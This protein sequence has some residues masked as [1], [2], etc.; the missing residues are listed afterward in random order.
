MSP[1]TALDR[2][3]KVMRIALVGIRPADQVI[4]KGYLR[5]L[6]RLEADL[7]W[8]SANHPQID[9]YMINSEFAQAESVQ[10]LLADKS[11]SAVL[12]VSRSVSDS[13]FLEGDILTLPLRDLDVLN[14]WLSRNLAFL[15]G[16]QTYT[17]QAAPATPTA[18]PASVSNPSINQPT[19][20]RRQSL[21]DILASRANQ[22]SQPTQPTHSP[23]SQ[24]P[25]SADL[26]TAHRQA[27]KPAASHAVALAKVLVQLQRREDSVLALND[28]SGTLLA[29]IQPKQQRVWQV[30]TA[31]E[32][33]SGWV[34][35]P[36]HQ[37][38]TP[39]DKSQDLVQW[40]WDKGQQ[41]N[42]A[43]A[44]PLQALVSHEQRYQLA[45]WAKPNDGEKRHAELKCQCVLEKRAVTVS[46]LA[47]LAQVSPA[48]AQRTVVSLLL[49][50][51]MTSDVYDNLVA[52]AEH[53]SAASPHDNAHETT[54]ASP[55][56]TAASTHSQTII[57]TGATDPIL[58]QPVL[59]T[60]R[61]IAQP[62]QPTP[63]PASEPVSSPT[64]APQQDNGMM[65]F[66]SKLRRKLGI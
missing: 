10:R 61:P 49:A 63:S 39:L 45:S 36:A 21:D 57:S 34:L 2:S 15:G 31:I 32:L 54:A 37:P 8:V 52:V 24:T 56:T 48:E 60:T 35:A 23:A 62:S 44:S 22:T 7:E 50:G 9:L 42:T 29:Y 51:L 59:A 3:K 28:P 46:E 13:G 55:V 19:A 20:P 66:L 4:L 12:Y 26:P 18:T 5:I 53:A 40:L 41:E 11:N 14:T 17:P 38:N 64:S 27:V 65:G 47:N 30:A 58:S 33:A 25:S 6:L 16:S 43:A 1:N